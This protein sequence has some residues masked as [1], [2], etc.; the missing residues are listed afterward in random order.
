MLIRF[1]S[2]YRP[3]A[4]NKSMYRAECGVQCQARRV[5]FIAAAVNNHS[6]AFHCARTAGTLCAISPSIDSLKCFIVNRLRALPHFHVDRSLTAV[7]KLCL[8]TV[9]RM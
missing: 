4:H 6:L 2:P 9:N 7:W 5:D 1:E 8:H 3:P